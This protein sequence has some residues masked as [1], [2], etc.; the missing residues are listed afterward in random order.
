MW[1][2]DPMKPRRILIFSLSYFPRFVG[3]AEIAIKETTDR[4][5]ASDM[6]FVM[7]TL[8]DG[9]SPKE[10]QMGNV[11]VHRIFKSSGWPHKLLFP[12]AAYLKAKKL[13]KQY[14]FDAVWSMMASY[15]GFAGFL[16]KRANPRIPFILSVQEGDNF[17]RRQ[18]IFHIPYTWIFKS[19][20]RIQAISN[21]LAEWAKDMHAT[22]PIE[23]IPN[24]VDFKH[25]SRPIEPAVAD[26]LK[27][28]LCKREGDV[29]LVTTSRLVAKNAVGDIIGSLQHLPKSIK[30]LVLG[31]G[32]LETALKQQT[33]KLG[34]NYTDEPPINPGNRV[35][36][37]GYVS[38]STMPQYLA[39]SDI[40]VRPSLSEG[41]G[42]S[43][44]EAMA[45]GLP[46][47]A[48]R[49]GG[50]PD[51]LK[52]GETGLFCEAENPKSIAQKV[53]KYLKDAESR[54]YIRKK[55]KA[56]VKDGYQWEKI[57]VDMSRIFR[58]VK[59]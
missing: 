35:H 34:L 39:V 11:L 21:Y 3:G 25:F 49:V 41:L 13:N 24:A 12:F 4:I 56:M 16:F 38:H 22:C 30:L 2:D 14:S 31:T 32:P 51:F 36:F 8:G 59:S 42:I 55:A 53:E 28:S 17:E 33:L 19:P 15:A 18:G 6:E 7:V 23:V 26:S 43:F 52:E 57:A 5:P 58:S 37:L 46:V 47:I 27:A 50:I 40:F 29:F 54:E 45:A 48:T 10:Q 1:K 9:S 44:L 20:D